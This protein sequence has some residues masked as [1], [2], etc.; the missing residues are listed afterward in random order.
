MDD[1][2]DKIKKASAFIQL[3]G[4]IISVDHKPINFYRLLFSFPVVY[5][6]KNSFCES[7]VWVPVCSENKAVKYLFYHV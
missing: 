3:Q 4:N 1:Y 6:L 5:Q 7:M 2:L